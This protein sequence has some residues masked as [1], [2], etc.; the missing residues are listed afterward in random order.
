[1]RRRVSFLLSSINFSINTSTVHLKGNA[2]PDGP[3]ADVNTNANATMTANANA[4]TDRGANHSGRTLCRPHS[5][6]STAR[7]GLIISCRRG[8]SGATVS[9]ISALSHCRAAKSKAQANDDH[10]CQ[11]LLHKVC[12]LYW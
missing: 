10:C 8:R 12:L 5:P 3:N 9:G 6:I 11:K 4:Y 7:D 1:M 2:D